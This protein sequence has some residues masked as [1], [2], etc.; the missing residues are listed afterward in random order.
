VTGLAAAA[1]A[2]AVA[3]GGGG[4]G[5]F[6]A[7]CPFSHRVTTDPIVSP[8]EHRAGHLHDFYGNRSTRGSSTN[9]SLRRSGRT[10]CTPRAD[11]SAYWTPTLFD[12][13]RPLKAEQ[14]TIYYSVEPELAGEVRP[15]PRNLR[16]V[17][18]RALWSCLASDI[19]GNRTRPPGVACPEGSRLELLVNFPDCWDGRRA[20]SRD[21]RSHMAYSAA[22]GCPGSHP[23]A[24][25]AL[26]FKIRW[27]SRGGP[28]IALSS[29]LA[30]TAHG[31]F[32]NAWRPAALQRRIDNCLK[33][34]VKCGATASGTP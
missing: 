8:G 3:A 14:V 19:D 23:V 7:D 21:H 33:P 10:T 30:R 12:R 26:Q 6:L 18:R 28:G 17:A 20:D 25:P 34:L 5:E 15:F 16:V 13:G 31:D 27:A 22:G 29:G 9:A 32:M 1:A 4:K 11:R 2:V 24:V